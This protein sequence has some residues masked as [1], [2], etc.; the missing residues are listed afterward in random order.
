MDKKQY[1]REWYFKNKERLRDT[2]N[3]RVRKYRKEKRSYILE[4]L[5]NSKCLNCGI[6]DYRVLEF[7]HR[8]PEEKSFNLG[9]STK[10][11]LDRIKKEIDKCD[12][13][14]ANCHRIK[15]IKQFNYYSEDVV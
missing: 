7:D 14:C 4:I 5:K 8:N 9:D 2:K 11:T 15:T 3:E 10:Y 1:D 13:L 12:I 6:N